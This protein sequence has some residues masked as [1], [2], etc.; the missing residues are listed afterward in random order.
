MAPTRD[1]AV[2]LEGQRGAED[3]QA[4]CEVGRAVDGVEDPAVPR[5]RARRRPAQ[6]LGQDGV[7][8]ETLADEGAEAALD[9]HVGLGDE[10]DCALL[11]DAQVV[12]AE[13]GELDTAGVEHRFDGG[14]QEQRVGRGRRRRAGRLR[15]W[16]ARPTA[17][18]WSSGPPCPPAARRCRVT[19]SMKL[20][21][22][23]MPRPLERSRFSGASG[24]ATSTGSKPSPSSVMRITSAVG[25][26]AGSS[27]NSTVT[28][29]EGSK[30]LPCLMALITDSRTE[31]PTQWMASSSSPPSALRRSLT[32]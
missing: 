16:P 13:R 23:K 14:R 32:T 29:F 19:S 3:R 26:A 25:A 10:V 8:G 6:L 30:R 24:S 27:E 5:R 1:D 28:R 7:V 9:R 15:H 20:R 17:G 18:A 22:K 31:T 12:L 21:M 4:V 2:D 11:V